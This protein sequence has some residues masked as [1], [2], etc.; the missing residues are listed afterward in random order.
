MTK[1]HFD[2]AAAMVRAIADGHW[3]TDPPSW[4]NVLRCSETDDYSRAVQTAEAFILLF[5][6]FNAQFDDRRFLIACKL[7]GPAS[8]AANGR[9]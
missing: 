3:T 1:K 5:R 8:V 4:A 7:L 6:E 2:T 9:K